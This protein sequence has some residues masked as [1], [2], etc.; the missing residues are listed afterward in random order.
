MWKGNIL[1]SKPGVVSLGAEK[2]A[3]TFR[4]LRLATLS[5]LSPGMDQPA[6][7]T[8]QNVFKEFVLE[9]LSIVVVET[10]IKMNRSVV[11]LLYIYSLTQQCINQF[12]CS[13]IWALNP[14]NTN[15]NEPL[16]SSQSSDRHG[17]INKPLQCS[18]LPAVIECHIRESGGTKEAVFCLAWGG[19]GVKE[20]PTKPCLEGWGV[21][22]ADK[23]VWESILGK[24]KKSWN[25]TFGKI[26]AILCGLTRDTKQGSVR[27]WG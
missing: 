11:P 23:G 19:E 24:D 3:D 17:H 13:N 2:K 12:L 1:G 20:G 22:Q 21:C 15:M 18:V 26:R 16:R 10:G 25:T 9:F 4:H 7:Q 27:R 5:F 8:T 6:A 14:G